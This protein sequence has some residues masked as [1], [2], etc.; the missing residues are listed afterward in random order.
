M[1]PAQL[2]VDL[3]LFLVLLASAVFQVRRLRS[4]REQRRTGAG[5]DVDRLRA[6][7][8]PLDLTQLVQGPRNAAV[9]RIRQESG[10]SVKD[11]LLV[12]QLAK[13]GRL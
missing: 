8:L 3:L 9:A 7:T 2:V 1:P 10:L 6:A 12:Y 5:P 4:L 11:S 13:S